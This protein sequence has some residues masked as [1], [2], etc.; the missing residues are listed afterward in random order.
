MTHSS[1]I[2]FLKRQKR[3]MPHYTHIL[4]TRLNAPLVQIDN[5]SKWCFSQINCILLHILYRATEAS[6]TKESVDEIAP[7]DH[8]LMLSAF[9]NH[10]SECG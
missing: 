5:P 4:E 2:N 10:N 3:R 9:E 1:I 6:L 8:N 7:D